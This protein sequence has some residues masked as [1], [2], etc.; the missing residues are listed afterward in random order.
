MSLNG[1]CLWHLISSLVL[2]TFTRLSGPLPL[3]GNA[4]TWNSYSVNFPR[5]VTLVLRVKLLATVIAANGWSGQSCFLRVIMTAHN[6]QLP[7]D[8]IAQRVEHSTG[9]IGFVEVKIEIPTRPEI[10]RSL[11]SID[12]IAFKTAMMTSTWFLTPQFQ[13]YFTSTPNF[14]ELPWTHTMIRFQLT[15]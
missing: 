7:V 3:A 1:Y 14:H 2:T 15:W 10:F 12:W 13:I 8:M 11:L 4:S 9:C 6:D 5:P